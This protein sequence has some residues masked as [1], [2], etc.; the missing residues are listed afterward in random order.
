MATGH[1]RPSGPV[2]QHERPVLPAGGLRRTGRLAALPLRHAARTAAVATRLSRVAADQVAARTAEQLFG[3]LGELKGGAAKLGQAMSV[4]EA[5]M[6]EELAAPYRA[7]LRRLT[8]A[9]PPMPAESAR[10]VVA[11]DLGAAFG[12]GWRE[13]LVAFGDTPLAAAS[14]G[15]VHR[16]RWRDDGG[17]IVEVAVKVQYPGVGQALRSDLR[18][19]RLLG[20]VMTR[21]TR[22]NVTGLAD[23]LALRIVE[24]LDYVRE[25]RVQSEVAAAFA[26]RVP[27]VI[28]DARAAGVREPEGRTRVTVPAV[29]AATPRVLITGWLDGVSLSTLLDGRRDLLPAGWRELSAGDAADLAARLLG[30]AVYAPAACSG[31][32]HADLHPGNFLLLPGGRLGMLD[33]GAVAATPGGIPAPFGQLAAAVLAGCGPMAV[34]LARRVGALAPGLELDQR[35][36]VELL[37]PIVA[38]AAPDTFTYSRPWLRGLMAH[39]TEPRFAPAL[40]NLTPPLEYAL[41]WRATLSAAGLFAQLGA[42]V[43]TRGFHLAYSPGFRG[44]QRLL[45]RS[46]QA[47]RWAEAGV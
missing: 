38:T 25:G 46:G 37:H 8:D 13:R 40:R 20:R 14:I 21:L 3:T 9:A 33:F 28:A 6:P 12:P 10:R 23:E 34:R 29:Y 32:M 47:G 1:V 26:D 27:E 19:A 22:L 16:G 35:L 24:E 2:A 15:Q 39:L 44:A 11:A 4:F 30:H 5:A 18:Q 43:P 41:V 45:P 42:T 17:Q 7:A 31:W 36:L